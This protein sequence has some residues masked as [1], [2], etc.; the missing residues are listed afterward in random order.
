MQTLIQKVWWGLGLC[1]SNW[2]QVM[3]LLLVLLLPG[4]HFEW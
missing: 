1:I 4:P 2:F 3:L